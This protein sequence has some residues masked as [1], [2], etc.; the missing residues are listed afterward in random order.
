MEYY[1]GIKNHVFKEHVMT[2]NVHNT[3]INEKVGLN[4]QNHPN[5]VFQK[6]PYIWKHTQDTGKDLYQNVKCGYTEY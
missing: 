4:E 2:E 6:Q 3:F 1:E 5:F